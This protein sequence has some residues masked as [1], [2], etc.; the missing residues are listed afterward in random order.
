MAQLKDSSRVHGSLTVDNELSVGFVTV[1][2]N[3]SVGDNL[4]VVGISTLDNIE[5]HSGIITANVGVITYYGDGRNLTDI[6]A[7]AEPNG[8]N[9]EVQ[10]NDNGALDGAE[11]FFY[12]KSNIRVGIGT[13]VPTARLSI[14][15]TA[16][17]DSLMQV[18]DNVSDGSAFKVNGSG[19]ITIL[20]IDADGTVLFMGNKNIGIGPLNGNAVPIPEEKLHID[21]NLKVEG[22]VIVDGGVNVSGTITAG[23]LNAPLDSAAITIPGVTGEIQYKNSSGVLDGASYFF[24]DSSNIRVGIGTSLPSARLTV[25]NTTTG[26]SLLAVTDN[27]SE[28]SQ[29]R[30]NNS[31]GG[32]LFDVDGDGT[33]RML[34]TENVGIGSTIIYPTSK[35]QVDGDVT[36]SAFVGGGTNLTSLNASQ[37]SSGTIPDARFPNPFSNLNVSGF[38]T[39]TGAADFNG[40]IDVNGHTELDNLNVSGFS[41]FSGDIKLN[42]NGGAI[43]I[44][45]PNGTSYQLSVDNSGNFQ[46]IGQ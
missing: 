38:S 14:A 10:F 20:D 28:G 17:G 34:T 12:D 8:V 22:T 4:S 44:K 15:N 6:T 37:L 3:L 26:D 13:S 7:I 27:V 11:Y 5:I 33:I 16:T 24:Y 43:F 45:S 42:Q 19:A 39:F 35:L 23:L 40:D 2:D 1:S 36:A 9:G 29:F 18:T 30:V 31:A 25:A 41:T 21:G 46:V 32:I